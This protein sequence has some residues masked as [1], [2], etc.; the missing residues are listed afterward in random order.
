MRRVE[1]RQ[2]HSDGYCSIPG[3]PEAPENLITN[4]DFSEGSKG[5]TLAPRP[6]TAEELYRVF[7]EDPSLTDEGFV[8]AIAADRGSGQRATVD[9]MVNF[10]KLAAWINRRFGVAP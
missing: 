5:W 2:E 10:T 9:G 6:V 4:G 8:G 7:D 1:L 3:L